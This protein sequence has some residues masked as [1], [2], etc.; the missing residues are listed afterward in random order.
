MEA[1]RR[2]TL[3]MDGREIVAREGM[4][5]LEAARENG[6]H[7]PTLCHHP[8]LSN[9]GG[10]RICVVEVDGAPRLVASCVMPVREGMDVATNSER[11][12]ESRR[13]ILEFLFAERNH[14]CMFCS[15]SGD[16]EL[17]DLA[18]ELGMDHLTVPPSFREFPVDAT[19]SYMVLDHNRCI[20]CARCVRACREI[21]GKQV[22]NF[23][24]RGAKTL[25]SKDL[26]ELTDESTCDSCGTCL[27]LCP[28]G[29]IYHRLRTHQA[30]R[31][32]ARK[33]EVARTHC[34]LCGILCETEV[35]VADGSV[36]AIDG[37]LSS[38]S[39]HGGQ[40]CRKG[41][42]EALEDRG[43]RLIQPMIRQPD[44]SL[45]STSW[46]DALERLCGALMASRGTKRQKN[47]LGLIS[48]GCPAEEAF[49]LG[50]ILER[51]LKGNVVST[52]APH[53]FTIKKAWEEVGKSFLGLKECSW[54]KLDQADLI[55]FAGAEPERTHPMIAA[56][57]K[58][59]AME[60][61]ATLAGIGP[62]PAIS[63]WSGIW[64]KVPAEELPNGVRALLR[65]VAT[66]VTSEPVARWRDLMAQI[67]GPEQEEKVAFMD[68]ATAGLL[69]EVAQRFALSKS[70][71]VIV[72]DGVTGSGQISTLRNL[73]F[74]A[75]LKGLLLEGALRL[76]ILKPR[77]N[78][79][80]SM[81]M[82]WWRLPPSASEEPLDVCF[83]VEDGC[84]S[85]SIEVPK[86]RFLA[87]MTSHLAGPLV[88]RAQVLIPKPTW[89]EQGGIF[90]SMDGTEAVQL[91]PIVDPPEGVRR[92]WE[93]LLAIGGRLGMR[94]LP[95]DTADLRGRTMEALGLP[96]PSRQ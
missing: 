14:Y 60:K 78:T 46:E 18:Y 65:E 95:K 21:A 34:P 94:G 53:L 61:G 49:L 47:V 10:C 76:L 2:V 93:T 67:E 81:R 50:E 25:V 92:G 16:C 27:Q 39:V 13:T 51:G 82:G 52:D 57:S 26:N 71:L 6:I 35:R 64:V 41:R 22:L 69:R 15:Q 70:P 77:G 62:N 59:A 40:L 38:S 73:M 20:L 90:L 56:L 43:P 74:L 79:M 89:L 8:A 9:W 48:G 75:L 63:S 32:K 68:S 19:S 87:L 66:R 86:T 96:S 83:V 36:V 31:G 80:S 85:P 58:R 1:A 4:T 5:I 12:L 30:V 11:V 42:F 28:T 55:L 7:I 72:G 44:G 37:V 84:D 54:E 91:F 17:Q 3:K 33:V 24:N 29:S 88:E 23:Q 45:R